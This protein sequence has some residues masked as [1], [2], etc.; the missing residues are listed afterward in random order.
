MEL[1]SLFGFEDR[2]FELLFSHELCSWSVFRESSWA[3]YPTASRSN[4]SFDRFGFPFAE[5]A[6]DL[7]RGSWEKLGGRHGNYDA[8]RAERAIVPDA[9]SKGF[10]MFHHRTEGSRLTREGDSDDQ[11][12]SIVYR[13]ARK[14][15]TLSALADQ[16]T[17]GCR[18]SRPSRSA[19][20]A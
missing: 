4:R 3:A 6:A 10:G 9:T 12:V 13:V 11:A 2:A 18:P 7:S 17:G 1:V 19:L 5:P 14:A 20:E 16:A 8:E 15:A